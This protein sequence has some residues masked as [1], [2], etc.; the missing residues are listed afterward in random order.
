MKTEQRPLAL[1]IM[2]GWGVSQN[3]DGNAIALADTSHIKKL[4]ATYPTT[5][6]TCSGEAVG[7]PEGQMGNSEVGHLNIGAGRVVYQELTRITKAIKDGDFF[8]NEELLK[9]VRNAKERQTALHIMGLLSDGGV[10]SHI[11]HIFATLKLARQEGLSRVCFHAFLDG[12]DVPPSSAKSYMNVLLTKMKEIGVGQ[13]ATV[14]GRYYAMDRDR[15]WERTELAYRA[16]V[17]SEGLQAN[18]PVEAIDVGYE[19]GETDEFIK[20]T[21][22]TDDQKQPVAKVADGDSV[23]FVNFRPDRA[24]QI[25]RAFVDEDFTG[26]DR[27]PGRP[28]VHFVCMTQYDKTIEAPVAFPPAKLVNTLGEWLSKHG[29]KQLRLAETEKYAHVTFFFNGGVEAA[30][31]GEE[32]IL[33]PSPKVATYDLKPEM[34]A[35]EITDTFLERLNSGQYDV[36]ITNF[37][38]PDMV[39]H[40]GDLQATEAAITTVDKCIGRI[41]EAMLEKSG[42]VIITGD[43]GNAD[44][45]RDEHGGAYTAHTTSPV[46]FILVDDRYKGAKLRNGG[47]LQD[48]APT[49]LDI[50][51]LPKPPEMTGESLLKSQG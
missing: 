45:M 37:A 3:R 47:S 49:M 7:L 2:D 4:M 34:S 17:Y 44:K 40:T 14:S 6:L 50:L 25:T 28:R 23:I 21:I 38:N 42:T 18:S 33:I 51:G 11:R 46:P 9:A 19:R 10:H 5:I 24:R 35:Y 41:A 29:L 36:I 15:R 27:G 39:G 43:H 12:R 32:R 13:V 20:P 48:I 16:L 22:I 1:I 26:F 30:N 31:P 8:Q